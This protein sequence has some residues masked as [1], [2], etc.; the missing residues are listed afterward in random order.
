MRDVGVRPAG[1][2]GYRL[3]PFCF[4]VT[5][6][7]RPVCLNIYR[8][9]YIAAGRIGTEFVDRII[10]ADGFVRSEDARGLRSREPGQSIQTP[11]VMMGIDS[12]DG[13]H[14]PSGI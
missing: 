1:C 9:Y 10:A 4:V 8:L 7:C 11:E 5:L 13:L 2:I 14:S 6:P 3:N 12:R